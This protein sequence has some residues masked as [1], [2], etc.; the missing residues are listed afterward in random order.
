M[1][2][3][4]VLEVTKGDDRNAKQHDISML[5]SHAPPAMRGASEF[6]VA[7][8]KPVTEQRIYV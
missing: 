1:R 6:R 5:L 8:R 3:N 7:G 2:Y 4:S